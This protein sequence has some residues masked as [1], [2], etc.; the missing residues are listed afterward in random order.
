MEQLFF[1]RPSL[2]R[3]CRCGQTSEQNCS[4]LG[5]RNHWNF[6]PFAYLQ[7]ENDVDLSYYAET[8]GSYFSPIRHWAIVGEIVETSFFIRPRARIQTLYGEQF[9]VNFHL[10]DAAMPRFFQWE[11]MKPGSSLCILYPK[12]HTFL[13]MTEGI[14]QENA[15]TVMVFPAPLAVLVEEVNA[16]TIS[17]SSP[18]RC[19]FNCGAKETNEKKLKRCSRCKI[20]VYCDKDGCQLP[21]WKLSHSKLCRCAE[22]LANLAKMDFSHFDNFR[23]WSFVV[24]PPLSRE[25][26]ES[27]ASKAQD[28]FLYRMGVFSAPIPDRL[29]K[30]LTAIESKN[31]RTDPTSK[32]ILQHE[33]GRFFDDPICAGLLVR[34]TFLFQSLQGLLSN[35]S[36]DPSKTYHVVDLKQ[37]DDAMA[38][39]IKDS[40]LNTVFFSLPQWQHEES[41]GG[42][43][44]AFEAHLVFLQEET[45]YPEELW[46]TKI[47]TGFIDSIMATNRV[48]GTNAFTSDCISMVAAMGEAMATSD[49]KRMVI[50]VLRATGN[51]S[52]E[53]SIRE[54]AMKAPPENLFTLWIRE[55]LTVCGSFHPPRS[56][57]SLVDQLLDIRRYSLTD[58]ILRHH[59]VGFNVTDH[60]TGINRN[61]GTRSQRVCASCG[62]VKA[63]VEFS[64]N[65]LRKP[66]GVSRCKACIASIH[67]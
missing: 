44:W 62:A 6:P 33:T 32:S 60:P 12:R 52:Y 15:E 42:I 16:H 30:L 64:K 57:L 31:L 61:P 5:L 25:E 11:D 35:L 43:S 10:E 45:L 27:M 26:R 38:E 23:D 53:E 7:D 20:A 34:E 13:D 40:I 59:G 51:S 4:E 65:Q 37:Q 19:C 14:R 48:S 9:Q 47:E 66:N 46:K 54:I 58:S 24:E 1:G 8:E 17:S 63:L 2:P 67:K 49:P 41:I 50:R 3:P 29:C 55:D 28:E 56:D 22:M 18:T 21:H 36:Q 39:F